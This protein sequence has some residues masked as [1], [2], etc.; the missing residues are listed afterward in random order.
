MFSDLLAETRILFPWVRV[1]KGKDGAGPG[2]VHAMPGSPIGRRTSR[3]SRCNR[4]G[5]HC[6]QSN[7]RSVPQFGSGL[8]SWVGSSYSRH[9]PCSRRLPES[10]LRWPWALAGTVALRCSQSGTRRG[11]IQCTD[12]THS[13]NGAEVKVAASFIRLFPALV[14]VVVDERIPI[15]RVRIARGLKQFDGD[16]GKPSP[17]FAMYSC[18]KLPSICS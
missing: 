7:R 13:G 4:S 17:R 11:S 1:F 2:S 9:S 6:S 18:W 12:S 14:V 10:R 3:G 15:A 5:F 16:P 8:S